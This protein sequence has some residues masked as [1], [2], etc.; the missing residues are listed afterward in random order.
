[1]DVMNRLFEKNDAEL[2]MLTY[3]VSQQYLCLKPLSLKH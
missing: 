2:Q 3:P 1:M